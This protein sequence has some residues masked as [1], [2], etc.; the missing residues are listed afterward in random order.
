[1]F[2]CSVIKVRCHSFEASYLFY[3]IRR[4]LSTTFLFIFK[5]LFDLT[6]S[7]LFRVVLA[8]SLYMISSL[9]ASVNTFFQFFDI[10][11]M[12]SPEQSV[13]LTHTLARERIAQLYIPLRELRFLARSAFLCNREFQWNFL[14]TQKILNTFSHTQDHYFHRQTLYTYKSIFQ[15]GDQRH[16][17]IVIINVF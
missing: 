14:I 11:L 10:F 6:D 3:Q 17:H 16:N 15:P 12:F 7:V 9:P 4:S 1:M 2:C 5:F 8:D 13:R